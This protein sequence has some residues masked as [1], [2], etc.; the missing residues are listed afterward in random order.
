VKLVFF[1]DLKYVMIMGASSIKI[2][3]IVNEGG[4]YGNTFKVL[5][6]EMSLLESVRM[7]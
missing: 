6:T 3:A 4:T 1:L 5:T 7:G 2:K